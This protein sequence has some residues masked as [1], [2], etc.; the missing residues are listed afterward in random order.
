[1]DRV[2]LHCDCNSFFASVETLDHPEYACVP[3]AVTGDPDNRHGIILAK[4][5]AAKKLG[6]QTAETIYQARRKCP[7]LL[8]VPPHMGKYREISRKINAIYLDYTDLV[9]AFSVDESY[10]D[11]T[12]SLHLFGCDARTLADTLRE[13]VRREVGITISVGVSFC[14]VFAKLGSDYRKPDATTVFDRQAVR[15]VAYA[16]PVSSLLYVGKKT[17][18]Q[19]S[20]MGISTIGELAA[21]DPALLQRTLGEQG[22]VISCYARGMDEEPVR[23]YY[24]KRD[25]KSIG[26]GT[27]FRRDL[28]TA[29]EIRV[30]LLMLCDEIVYRLRESGK[31]CTVLQVTIRDPD[32][33]T[34][35]RQCPLPHPTWL[36]DALVETAYSLVLTNWKRGSRIRMLTVTA[37]GLVPWNTATEQMTVFDTPPEQNRTTK[38]EKLEA[39]LTEIRRRKGRAS[40]YRGIYDKEEIGISNCKT[41]AAEE[42][43]K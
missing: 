31:M 6:V 4:N 12:G 38:K 5:E 39:A 10:L 33:H 1:M 30:G 24:E 11:V 36:Q 29:E 35:Q 37:Q 7:S 21:A 32:F 20:W 27:T 15:E 34:I 13:R 3:M 22:R 16:L 8:C 2:I 25:T 23:S 19:L 41:D 14:K 18:E 17:A 26:N 42:R 40:I 28:M 43:G 9:E